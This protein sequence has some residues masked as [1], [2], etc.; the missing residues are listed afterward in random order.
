MVLSPPAAR[1]HVTKFKVDVP[2]Q[3]WDIVDRHE[4][5]MAKDILQAFDTM[6]DQVTPDIGALI[7][8]G[9]LD[10]VFRALDGVRMPPYLVDTIRDATTTVAMTT[11]MATAAQ[12]GIRWNEVNPRVLEWA[13]RYTLQVLPAGMTARN[14]QYTRDLI[15]TGMES[16]WGAEKIG[17][18]I[19]AEVPLL[20]NHQ[21][22]INRMALKM[23][24]DGA[25]A[26]YIE[27]MVARRTKKLTRWRA[28]MIA[29]TETMRAANM[30]QIFTWETA[31]QLNY[32]PDFTRKVWLATGDD[33]T[34]PICA[35]MDGQTVAVLDESGIL[36]EQFEVTHK[37]TSMT[38]QGKV[39]STAPLSKPYA[40]M[41]PPAHPQCRCT[42]ILDIPDDAFDSQRRDLP[43]A[44]GE[45]MPG[46]PGY[47]DP[48][49]IF[50]DDQWDYLRPM[51]PRTARNTYG[52]DLTSYAERAFS[53]NEISDQFRGI[54]GG[55]QS[56]ADV[57][58]I[59][60]A[61]DDLIRKGRRHMPNNRFSD[62]VDTLLRALRQ[63]PHQPPQLHRGISVEADLDEALEM[64]RPGNRLDMGVSSFSEVVDVA[65]TFASDSM[66]ELSGHWSQNGTRV[67]FNIEQEGMQG[68]PIMNMDQD[69]IHEQEWIVGG[70]FEVLDVAQT[71]RSNV[72]YVTL[73]QVAGL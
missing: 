14:V 42:M 27:R 63:N 71:T 34:C 21:D 4:A 69:F 1:H 67:I 9:D 2:P 12:F 46:D 24:N 57:K 31:Q 70:N 40:T 20:P 10:A 68:L 38:A 22:A 15:I 54:I 32:L 16:G 7:E 64:F 62:Q 33:R 18:M 55:W 3:F 50:T 51:D 23:A 65:E 73:R 19:T 72:L 5:R 43:A 60:G 41:S 59:R 37:A 61:V 29:R 56:G 26:R 25:S 66:A 49:G 52:V 47:T 36:G 30:G 58:R 35:E 13:E 8:A 17:R 44:P 48:L 39:L 53:N 11:G 28:N 45:S 6:Q